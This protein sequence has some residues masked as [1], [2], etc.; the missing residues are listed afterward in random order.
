MIFLFSEGVVKR[1]M[2][3]VD[4]VNIT[5]TNAARY[6]RLYPRKG[7]IREGSDADLSI[8]D[9][10]AEWTWG[11]SAIAGAADYSVLEGLKLTGKI[12]AV[13]KAGKVAVRDGEVLAQKGS[14]IFIP[15]GGK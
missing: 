12:S 5:A 4:F 10:A 2:S 15:I 8:I 13:I 9:P 3:M 7:V 1:N 11:A 14:G 6:Y